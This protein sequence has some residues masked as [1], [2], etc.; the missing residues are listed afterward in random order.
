MKIH[1]NP[2]QRVRGKDLNGGKEYALHL[3]TFL[4]E[5]VNISGNLYLLVIPKS[6]LLDLHGLTLLFLLLL[7][8]CVCSCFCCFVVVV[9]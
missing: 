9:V 8:Y 4:S 7:F 1:V 6:S 2:S 3:N 5:R